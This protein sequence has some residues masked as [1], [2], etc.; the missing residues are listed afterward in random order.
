MVRT[1]LCVSLNTLIVFLNAAVWIHAAE[2]DQKEVSVR[3]VLNV[4]LLA[5]QSNMAGAESVVPVPPGFQQTAAD[6]GTLFTMAPLPQ[7]DAAGEYVPWGDVRGHQAKN[8][9]V[10]GPEVG[11][12]RELFQ[13]NVRNMALIKVHANFR[14]DVQSWPWAEGGPLFVAWT[15]FVD[16]RLA[17]L[18][19]RGHSIRV[20]GFLWHQG[21]D[22]AIHGTLAREYE[23]N[24]TDLITVLRT[25]YAEADTPFILARS[26]NSRI[27]QPQPDPEQKSAM[28]VVRQA[29]VQVGMNVPSA[30]WINVD[31]LPN[32]NTHHFSAESQL[33]IGRRFGQQRLSLAKKH[34]TEKPQSSEEKSDDKR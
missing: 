10:H 28:A 2:P 12:A 22:D 17:E 32:V 31:D 14:R 20:C 33:I 27:A 26:V 25:R 1:V 9:L 3:P 18:R 21:I 29:Q 15:Q 11:F 13:A 19:Q 4:F 23:K 30:A 6:R 5:G 7:G 8:Q 34:P 24:L 16:A